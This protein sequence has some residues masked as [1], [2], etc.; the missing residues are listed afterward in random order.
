[1]D[2]Q[3]RFSQW[4]YRT[5]Q[6]AWEQTWISD[7][8]D[9]TLAGIS[10]WWDWVALSHHSMLSTHPSLGCLFYH[11]AH[12]LQNDHERAIPAK[13]RKSALLQ[14]NILLIHTPPSIHW[15]CESKSF[16]TTSAGLIKYNRP[17]YKTCLLVT[18]KPLASSKHWY[19]KSTKSGQVRRKCK[20]KFKVHV[21]TT[22]WSHMSREGC[23]GISLQHSVLECKVRLRAIV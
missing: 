12:L 2:R 5:K 22:W 17:S 19:I 6:P 7:Y 23:S 16:S 20:S 1:M 8:W 9:V 10:C 14:N 3:G 4:F 15:I 18:H 11:L 13:Q 21:K